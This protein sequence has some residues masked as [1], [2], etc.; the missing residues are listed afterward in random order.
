MILD[1]YKMLLRYCLR[2]V[3]DLSDQICWTSADVRLWAFGHT[4]CNC[5]FED[6]GTKKRVVANQKG[7]CR[8]EL[9]TFDASKV[10]KVERLLGSEAKA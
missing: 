1:I 7:Y 9:E 2:N 10:V 4:H 6:L 8:S 3:T 5:D